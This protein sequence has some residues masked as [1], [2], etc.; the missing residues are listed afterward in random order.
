V[1]ELA[2]FLELER[3]D[4]DHGKLSAVSGQP[5]A[6]RKLCNSIFSGGC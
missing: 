5:S 4:V 6:Y 1:G 3:I 2:E